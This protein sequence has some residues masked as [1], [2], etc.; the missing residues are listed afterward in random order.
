M[1]PPP[2]PAPKTVWL[3]TAV[4]AAGAHLPLISLLMIW[5]QE[6]HC[7]DGLCGFMESVFVWLL[8]GLVALAAAI[9]GLAR[10]ER[11]RWLALVALATMVLPMAVLMGVVAL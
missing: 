5:A 6:G 8:C 10:G 1:Q 4:M 9:V 3:W 2:P 11:P 7:A